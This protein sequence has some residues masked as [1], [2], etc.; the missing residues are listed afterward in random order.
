MIHHLSFYEYFHK[1][2]EGTFVC[3]FGDYTTEEDYQFYQLMHKMSERYKN[4]PCYCL[5]WREYSTKLKLYQKQKNQIYYISKSKMSKPVEIT[6]KIGIV[7]MFKEVN[8]IIEKQKPLNHN[9]E[10]NEDPN[11]GEEMKKKTE[12]SYLPTNGEDVKTTRDTSEDRDNLKAFSYK[13]KPKLSAIPVV[14][15][16]SIIKQSVQNLSNRTVQ[17]NILHTAKYSCEK[18]SSRRTNFTTN[19]NLYIESQQPFQNKI[20]DKKLKKKLT[21]VYPTIRKYSNFLNSSQ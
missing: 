16:K 11:F 17:R 5:D 3:Y 9:L 8:D 21:I 19:K 14:I 15:D 13:A 7:N 18:K 10:I 1:L 4:I 6:D 20:R 12:V 2:K